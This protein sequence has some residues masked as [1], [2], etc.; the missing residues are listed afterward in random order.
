MRLARR[1]V[2]VTLDGQ[3]GDELLAGYDHYP[4]VLLRQLLRERRYAEFAREAWL[5]RDIVTPAGAPAVARARSA[6]RCR[7]DARAVVHTWTQGAG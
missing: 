3:A 4:Y 5:L 6:R 7:G 1:Q 2:T